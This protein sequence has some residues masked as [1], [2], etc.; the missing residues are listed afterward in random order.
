MKILSKITLLSL[1]C[2]GVTQSYPITCELDEQIHEVFEEKN[3]EEMPIFE[4][5][6]YRF[7][8]KG[9]VKDFLH[10]Q[11]KLA[12]TDKY[13]PKASIDNRSWFISNKD[14]YPICRAC[15]EDFMLNNPH[16]EHPKFA[17]QKRLEKEEKQ[18]ELDVILYEKNAKKFANLLCKLNHEQQ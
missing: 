4:L 2:A 7:R 14:A 1:I 11:P 15:I 10:E 5:N 13:I 12:Y 18:K 8:Y 6:D 9:L 3:I 17:K 16:L